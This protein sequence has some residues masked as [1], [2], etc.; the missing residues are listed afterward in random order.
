MNDPVVLWIQDQLSGQKH[1][2]ACILFGSRARSDQR[3]ESDYDLA[4]TFRSDATPGDKAKTLLTLTDE[5]P[6]LL[7]LDVVD[8]NEIQDPAFKQRILSEG[9]TIYSQ[10]R[11]PLP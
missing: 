8:L 6:T 4:L 10:R 5:A 7:K 2:E 1:V 3:P 9:K 11:N